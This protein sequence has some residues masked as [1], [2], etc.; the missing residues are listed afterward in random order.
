MQRSLAFGNIKKI[1]KDYLPLRIFFL[2]AFFN[3]LIA[4]KIY[5]TK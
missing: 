2:R 5:T 3:Y 1:I 4:N